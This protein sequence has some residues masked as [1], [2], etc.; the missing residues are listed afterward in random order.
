M[1]DLTCPH[2]K[3]DFKT[4]HPR[5]KF[6]SHSCSASFTQLGKK[7]KY[8]DNICL[9]CGLRLNYI[10]RK[11]CSSICHLRFR[12]EQK[13]KE[14]E[15]GT[16]SNRPTIKKYLITAFG[17]YCFRCETETWMNEPVPLEVDHI[18]GD[19]GNNLPSNLRLLCPNCHA[20]TETAKGKNRGNGRKTRGLPLSWWCLVRESN[21]GC[22]LTKAIYYH[23]NNE[24]CWRNVIASND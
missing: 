14:V 10:Q 23:C 20:Q 2:C 21:T 7:R 22:R 11:F 3:V 18:D 17:R 6:C 8:H 12:N 5:Q 9:T 19:A 16:V 1:R 24:V 15:N 13:H 4:K